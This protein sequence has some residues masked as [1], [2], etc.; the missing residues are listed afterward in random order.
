VRVAAL[1]DLHCGV[2]GEHEVRR[3]LEGVGD[4]A[5]VLVMG[6]DLTN[7]GQLREADALVA[8]LAE[9]SIPVAAV[10]G[11]HDHESDHAA[12]LAQLLRD[13]GV[14]ILQDE[15]WEHGGVGFAGVKG[16]G[17]GF[18]PHRLTPFGERA[19]KDFVGVAVA[20]ATALDHQLAS[21]RTRHRVVVLHYAPVPAT[22]AGEPPAIH[23][24]LGDSLLE[25][26]V[27]RHGADVVVHGHAHD[28][29]AEGVTRGGVRVLNVSRQV[30]SRSPGARPYVTF[31][32]PDG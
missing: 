4:A 26:V 24:F 11:N 15:A 29:S 17:V 5:D 3:L 10:L 31:E 6:G 32:I 18:S 14:V 20:E 1:A 12:E 30:L 27:D 7:L 19:I 16:F 25:E 22:L 9:I 13:G 2:N 23:S 28:G 21:L 8:A